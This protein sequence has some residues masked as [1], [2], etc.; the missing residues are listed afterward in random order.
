MPPRS[1]RETTIAQIEIYVCDAAFAGSD[2]PIELEICRSS[3]SSSSSSAAS[4]SSDSRKCCSTGV[5][6][7]PEKDDF[8]RGDYEV[9]SGSQLRACFDFPVDGDTLDMA[10]AN[11]GSDGV[12]FGGVIVRAAG[13][14][15]MDCVMPIA[16]KEM[17]STYLFSHFHVF[18]KS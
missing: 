3:S 12:C 18:V 2:S 7:R 17:E 5:L 8:E 1:A 11:R 10:V 4:N 9:Y 13:G 16:R 14:D 15:A 6:D